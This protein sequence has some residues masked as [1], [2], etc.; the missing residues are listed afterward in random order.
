MCC[1]LAH[2]GKLKLLAFMDRPHKETLGNEWWYD[3]LEMRWEA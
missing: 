1:V 3:D 2:A